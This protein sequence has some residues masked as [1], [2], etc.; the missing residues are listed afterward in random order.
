VPANSAR[1]S[2][3]ATRYATAVFELAREQ[4]KLDE[5]AAD[6]EAVGRLLVESADLRRL[7]SSPI[8]SREE[9]GRAIAAVTE[10]AGL[11]ELSRN[12]LGVLAE[13][14]RLFALDG[15][16]L[17]F[18][19]MLAE[20]RG[21]VQ[22]EVISASELGEDQLK[23]LRESVERYAGKEVELTRTVDSSLLGG[24]VV[25]VGSRMIDASLK[26]KLQQL[27]LSMRGIG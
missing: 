7:A 2:G 14:R 16:I 24:L 4:K 23:A 21:V 22:A 19:R 3:I 15:I 8:L 10:R 6:L 18:G 27:E 9:Q 11:G 25:R 5:V 12:F 20:H 26:S 1:A 17:A 13:N